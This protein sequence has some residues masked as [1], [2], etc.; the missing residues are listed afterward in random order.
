MAAEALEMQAT[1]IKIS[2][3]ADGRRPSAEGWR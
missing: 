2:P 1:G 3:L